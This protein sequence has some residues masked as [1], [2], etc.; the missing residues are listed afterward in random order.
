M[1]IAQCTYI[2]Y[3]SIQVVAIP[4]TRS[5]I[6]RSPVTRCKKIPIEQIRYHWREHTCPKHRWCKQISVMGKWAPICPLHVPPAP[7][8]CP[9]IHHPDVLLN[10]MCTYMPSVSTDAHAHICSRALSVDDACHICLASTYY[11]HMCPHSIS[12]ECPAQPVAD[13]G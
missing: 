12:I 9:T 13:E 8:H 3:S 10:T 2:N 5:H 6:T 1:D 11:P 4:N 7:G